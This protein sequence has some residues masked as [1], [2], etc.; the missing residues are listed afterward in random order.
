VRPEFAAL[1]ASIEGEVIHPESPEYETVR[2]PAWAQ[3]ENVRPQAVVRCRTATDVA[4]SLAVARRLDLEATPRGGGHCFAGR[5]ATGGLVIDLSAMSSV[6]AAD[7]LA[8][9]GSGARLGEIDD[10]L[11]TYALAIP[12]G[13]C[14]AVGIAGLTLGGGLG[15]LGRSYGLT[16]DQL[17][18]A[19][20]VL[21]DGRVVECD[22]RREE[23]L[24]WAL[25]GAGAGQFGVVTSFSFRT[26]PAPDLTCFRLLWPLTKA[27]D[28]LEVW[29]SWAPSAPDELAASLLLNLP[30]D[31]E[32]L[33]TATLFGSSLAAKA[34]TVRLLEELVAAAG[35]DPTSTSIEP[36][37]YMAAKRYLWE[38]APGAEPSGAGLAGDESRPAL[39]FSKSEFFARELPREAIAALVDHLAALR[40]HGQAR[41]L[42]FT[43]WGGAYT[44][45]APEATAFPH[46]RERF[47]LKHAVSLDTD[48]ST[49]R[50]DAAHGWLT[51][52]WELVHPWGSGG[53]FPNFADPGLTGLATAYYGA[54]RDR[55]VRIKAEYDADNLFRSPAH[56]TPCR[57]P[58]GHVRK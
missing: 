49:E 44:R 55:L 54:N 51:R 26:V 33:P 47:L 40:A 48:A 13:S 31:P 23:G 11:A 3:Y 12:A 8:T 16:S 6:S 21:A 52:S 15:I 20:V 2:R 28:L 43:P 18:Q 5:S 39:A 32:R 1:D 37:Q 53:V 46:R 10:R 14:P 45:L 17:A 30:E 56:E 42:D 41:E 7:G 57:P 38:H 24:F 50:Q 27:A 22:E 25:R 34:E 9:V 29:Q 58:G 19:Q 36:L 4:E 35:E